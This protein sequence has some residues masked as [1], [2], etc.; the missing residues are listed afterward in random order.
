MLAGHCVFVKMAKLIQIRDC[1]GYKKYAYIDPIG[2]FSNH[3][4]ESVENDWNQRKTQQDSAELYTPKIV[5]VY[6]AF[7]NNGKCE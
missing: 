3:T 1:C 6:K 4:V 2:R 5:S 7:F